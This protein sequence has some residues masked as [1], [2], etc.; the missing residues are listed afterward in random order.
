MTARSGAQISVY[1]EDGLTGNGGTGKWQTA[2]NAYGAL[3]MSKCHVSADLSGGVHSKGERGHVI[4]SES[5]IGPCGW[6]PTRPMSKFGYGVLA[7]DG[8]T[9]QVLNC[10]VSLVCQTGVA[11]AGAGASAYV[12]RCKIGPCG[13]SGLA[14]EGMGVVMK[15]KNLDIWECKFEAV[16]APLAFYNYF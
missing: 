5:R 10:D 16:C 8:G 9:A 15:A 13:L 3:E 14:S 1:F 4:V 7:R 2:V 12:S 11:C 6:V